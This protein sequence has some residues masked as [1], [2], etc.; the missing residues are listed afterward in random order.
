MRNMTEKAY[1]AVDMGA[2]SGRHLLGFFDGQR[3]RLE[4]VYRFVNGPHELAGHLHWDLLS[5][6]S[7]IRQGLRAAGGKAGSRIISVGVDTWGLDFG[8]LGRG[9]ELLGNPF[10]YRDRQTDGM[11]EAASRLVP[12]EEIFRRTGLQFMPINTLYQL[13][14]MKIS[15]SSLLDTA[16]SLLM[17]PDLFHWLMTG[18]KC[19]EMT[20]AST[21]QF[22]DPIKADW[23][24]ELLNKFALPTHIL[25]QITPPGTNLGPLRKT[26]IAETG[27]QNAN[28]VLPGTHDTASA[29]VAVP[30]IDVCTAIELRPTNGR[31]GKEPNGLTCQFISQANINKSRPHARPD[32]CY[33]SLGTWALMGIESPRPMVTDAVLR[34]NFTNEAG[35]GGTTRILKNI[36]GMW[37]LQEC[38]RVW[39]EAGENLDWETLNRL[40]A[41]E[42]SLRSFV[43]PD[44]PD[45]LAPCDMPQAIREFC[46][47][48]GQSVPQ[49][50]G[51]VVRCALESIAMK[52]RFVFGMCEDLAGGRIETIH[53][54]GGGTKNRLLCQATADA[55]HRRVVAG[56]VEATAIGNLLV[57]AIAAG[58]AASIAEARDIVRRSF[59]L[60]EYEP[61]N[62]SVWD[63][64]YQRF[65]TIL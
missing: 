41:A 47:R 61:Q 6:W 38:R 33:I 12:R 65:L 4:E 22:F 14:A 18:V 50:K 54:V 59:A 25:G 46:R 43:D 64:A 5:Q 30:A 40:S 10:H 21:T 31:P 62:S 34:L 37:L 55:C 60:D 29:V 17:I 20:D 52:F 1:L 24:T 32:W 63:D 57:Q 11:I 3:L 2:S 53:I 49:T 9:D 35:V 26:L 51:A 45:F 39:N 56:P 44:A 36:A 16:E 27:I 42:P 15:G 13:L 8:L 58:D 23:S 7:Q 28:V 19:N 48:T